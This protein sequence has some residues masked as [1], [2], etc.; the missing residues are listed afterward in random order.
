MTHALATLRHDAR[1]H[2]DRAGRVGWPRFDVGKY[3]P[4]LSAAAPKARQLFAHIINVPTHAG[5]AGVEDSAVAL[6]LQRLS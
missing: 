3:Y 6:L 2:G 1:L 5:M 4:P